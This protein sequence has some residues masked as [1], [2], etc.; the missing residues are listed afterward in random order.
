MNMLLLITLDQIVHYKRTCYT[1]L[2]LFLH[3]VIG[4]FTNNYNTV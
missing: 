2:V 4:M 1:K 3:G